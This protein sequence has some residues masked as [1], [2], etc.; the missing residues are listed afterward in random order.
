MKA[1]AVLSRMEVL[2]ALNVLP[3]NRLRK[4]GNKALKER[5]S[6]NTMKN[7]KLITLTAILF[8]VIII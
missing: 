6:I 1:M 2:L 3:T 4:N 7:K 5:T 8:C